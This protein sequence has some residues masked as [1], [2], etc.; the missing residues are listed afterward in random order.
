MVN[1]ENLKFFHGMSAVNG[2]ENNVLLAE[3]LTSEQRND[4]SPQ[5]E[6][7]CPM[8]NDVISKLRDIEKRSDKPR[9]GWDIEDAEDALWDVNWDVSGLEDELE[10]I[11][12]RIEEVRAWGQEWKELAKSLIG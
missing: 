2:I 5:P 7:A 3:S 8:I 4:I 6:E 1:I 9:A 10:K 11:R 12:T